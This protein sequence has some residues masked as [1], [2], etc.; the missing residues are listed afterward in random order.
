[1]PTD[2]HLRLA[3]LRGTRAPDALPHRC[4]CGAR[5]AGSNTCHCAAAGCHLTFVGAGAFERHRRGGEC[6]DPTLIGMTQAPGRAYEAWT[7]AVAE[8]VAA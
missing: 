2:T 3:A 8:E 4:R 6:V 1:M 5:W 7:L